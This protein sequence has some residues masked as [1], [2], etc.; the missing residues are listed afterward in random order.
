MSNSAFNTLKQLLSSKPLLAF[1]RV[2]DTF[3]VEVDASDYAVGGELSQIDGR[4]V[5]RPVAYFSNLLKKSQLNWSPHTKEAFA[6]VLAVRQWYIYLKGM[7]F[8]IKSDHNPLSRLR[9]RKDIKGKIGRWISELEEFDYRVMY[10]PGKDNVK[11][12]ALSRNRH[13][14]KE[15][16]PSRFEE[17]IYLINHDHVFSNV[18]SAVLSDTGFSARL[19]EEQEKDELV[20][21]AKNAILTKR[22]ILQGRFERIQ[23][24]LQVLDGI[25]TKAGR[26]II[27]A[28][29]RRFV[30]ETVHGIGHQGVE[31]TY[32][33][34][35][36]KFYW[37]SMY[38]SVK[39]FVTYCQTCQRTKIDNHPPKAPI[40]PLI[41]LL[42]L[43]NSS[44]S[45]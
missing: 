39:M 4:G 40:I 41:D 27:P 44:P 10:I 15:Q 34:V 20:A 18:L 7:T 23:K 5:S 9:Q 13:A 11:A 2:G 14:S 26:P 35:K 21:Y 17:H 30:L 29:L 25:L 16:P 1:P 6:L 24:Q 28:T 8:V 32:D 42:H 31:T 43:C 38:N 12:G 3:T 37:P 33:L 22:P 45:T 19:R 36:S